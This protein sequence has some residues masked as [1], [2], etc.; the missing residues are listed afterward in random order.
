MV[1][2]EQSIQGLTRAVMTEAQAQAEQTLT[3][4]RVRAEAIQQ[5]AQA[6]ADKMRES[7]LQQAQQQAALIR[8]QAMASAQLEAKRLQMERRE[9]LLNRVFETARQRLTAVQGWTTYPD[10]VQ[11]LVR[12]GAIQLNAEAILVHADQRTMD[13]LPDTVMENLSQS[14]SIELQ[15]GAVLKQGIG[16]IVETIDGHR[17]FDNTLEA[18]LGRWQDT[19]RTPVYHLLMGESL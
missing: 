9:A 1:T 7:I 17:Q 4:A 8:S 6:R 3:D 12:E 16:V 10:V 19:L 15:R 11:K 18:R 2:T 5:Q 13:L 14:L